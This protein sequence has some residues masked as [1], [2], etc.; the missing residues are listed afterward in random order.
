MHFWLFCFLINFSFGC[1]FL[2]GYEGCNLL[3]LETIWEISVLHT[4]LLLLVRKVWIYR[5]MFKSTAAPLDVFLSAWSGSADRMRACCHHHSTLVYSVCGHFWMSYWGE[6]VSNWTIAKFTRMMFEAISC[7]FHFWCC[8]RFGSRENPSS[9]LPLRTAPWL[10]VASARPDCRSGIRLKHMLQMFIHS[11]L[12]LSIQLKSQDRCRAVGAAA[13]MWRRK[14]LAQ[15][16][17]SALRN[18][19]EAAS[20]GTQCLAWKLD[21][22]RGKSQLFHMTLGHG[23]VSP[24]LVSQTE[25][26]GGWG[27]GLTEL[28]FSYPWFSYPHWTEG[29]GGFN[30]TTVQ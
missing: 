27:G 29:W 4:P 22:M 16:A 19:A 25:P 15:C 21:R 6:G 14:V 1:K 30:W 12:E 3:V 18:S 11:C 9:Q 5:S 8:V 20:S 28:Q 26:G 24:G 23:S 2:K 7:N 17:A 10:G 13:F